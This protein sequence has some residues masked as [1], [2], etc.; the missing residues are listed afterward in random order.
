MTK[1]NESILYYSAIALL[2]ALGISLMV[3][4]CHQETSVQ[5]A[6][7][8]VY[9]QGPQT[10]YVQQPRQESHFWQDVMLYH[11]LFG[12]NS[13]PVTQVHVYQPATQAAPVVNQVTNVTVNKTVNVNQAATAAAASSTKASPAATLSPGT[14]TSAWAGTSVK[15]T[16]QAGAYSL[17][18]NYATARTTYT[19]SSFRASTSGRR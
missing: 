14:S 13:Q 8:P 12:G 19:G 3:T 2:G 15:A 16:T 17:K 1:K 11:F 7:A 5:Q 4:A 9:Q 18:S 6:Q 10:V